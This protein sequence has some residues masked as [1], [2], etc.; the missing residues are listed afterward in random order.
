MVGDILPMRDGESSLK[1][2]R[3]LC[4]RFGNDAEDVRVPEPT[5]QP[6]KNCKKK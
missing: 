6:T 3:G 1:Y 5:N 2:D 4:K